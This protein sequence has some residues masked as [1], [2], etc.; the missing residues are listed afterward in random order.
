M[1]VLTDTL[2]L[3]NTETQNQQLIPVKHQGA[4]LDFAFAQ[5]G[6]TVTIGSPGRNLKL[7]HTGTGDVIA[8][9]KT[10]HKGFISQVAFSADDKILASGSRGGTVELWDVL[11]H[12]RLT[13][14]RGHTDEIRVLAFA[15]DG[16]TV[17]TA[18]K[19]ETIIVLWDTIDIGR[20]TTLLAENITETGA[21]A[22]SP[23]G[24]TIVSGT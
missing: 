19:D 14:L 1:A 18:A 16:K 6:K 8:T 3:W 10:A 15:P 24:K 23:D 20:K 21:V 11:N 12:Q 2:R 5:D 9:F 4:A 7:R 13:T 17:A 22:F